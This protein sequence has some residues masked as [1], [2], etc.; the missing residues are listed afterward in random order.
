M[1]KIAVCKPQICEAIRTRH[2]I[3]TVA[4]AGKIISRTLLECHT[5]NRNFWNMVMMLQSGAPGV[6]TNFGAGYISL[7]K[8]NGAVSAIG[9]DVTTILLTGPVNDATKGIVVGGGVGAEDF[10]GYAL[11]S[12]IPHGTAGT[13]L[14]YAANAASTQSYNAE[15][16]K[17]T[18]TLKRSFTNSSG[19]SIDVKEAAM[20]AYVYN[21]NCM[22]WRDLLA[23][24]VAV[25]NNAVL[26]VA[27]E[28]TLTL[29][30]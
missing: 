12:L 23:A 9:P 24:T 22:I 1:N 14:L 20:Y 21:I 28:I 27:Y 10:E 4:V 29:P 18:I 15:L 6:V 13:Q 5:T 3:L 19:A 25:A 7:K 30:A 2:V 17:W 26:T 11:T 16:L 8:T